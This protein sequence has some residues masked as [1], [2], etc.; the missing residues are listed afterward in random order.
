MRTALR[1]RVR[2]RPP[3]SPALSLHNEPSR[4]RWQPDGPFVAYFIAVWREIFPAPGMMATRYL[5]RRRWA[6]YV[7]Q[8][9]IDGTWRARAQRFVG[10]RSVRLVAPRWQFTVDRAMADALELVLGEGR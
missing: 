9:P 6:L 4:S 8:R 7:D 3:F 5:S 10:C 2:R 1:W